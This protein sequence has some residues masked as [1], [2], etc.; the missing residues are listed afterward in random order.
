MTYS[1]LVVKAHVNA[2]TKKD[3]TFV[4][5]HDT[6][7]TARPA[8]PGG[9]KST[10]LDLTYGGLAQQ[11]GRSMKEKE[12]S[13]NGD[14]EAAVQGAGQVVVLHELLKERGYTGADAHFFKM[15]FYGH[16][17]KNGLG[18]NYGSI[19]NHGESAKAAWK[20]GKAARSDK[21]IQRRCREAAERERPFV[22]V[23]VGARGY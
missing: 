5:A 8:R 2:Y 14:I 9:R 4:S 13:V 21:E 22:K 11:L 10:G 15:G 3:G 12:S 20:A 23:G 6:S 18:T 1:I 16:S 17:P 7:A 19:N